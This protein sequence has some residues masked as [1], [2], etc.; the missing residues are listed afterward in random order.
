MTSPSLFC[1]KNK[2]KVPASP[3]MVATL[4]CENVIYRQGGSYDQR[5]QTWGRKWINK[6]N[7]MFMSKYGLMSD[8][9]ENK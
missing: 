9:Q 6:T 3:F 7:K 4:R 1:S 5:L 2:T 8:V